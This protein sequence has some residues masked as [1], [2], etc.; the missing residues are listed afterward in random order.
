M[1]RSELKFHRFWPTTSWKFHSRCFQAPWR[2][3]KLIS[4]HFFGRLLWTGRFDSDTV[5]QPQIFFDIYN[6]CLKV[7]SM[8]MWIHN[9]RVKRCQRRWKMELDEKMWA[10]RSP[11][12]SLLEWSHNYQ[13]VGN[14]REKR[15]ERGEE[16]E[17]IHFSGFWKFQWFNLTFQK[18][19]CL[20]TIQL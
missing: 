17:P 14:K 7:G 5:S 3:F 1:Y 10:A 18:I 9:G 8:V 12:L 4:T 2:K 16:Y 19:R 13:R 15:G 20:T 11:F 6:Y